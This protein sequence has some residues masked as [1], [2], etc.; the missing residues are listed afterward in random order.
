MSSVNNRQEDLRRRIHAAL[1]EVLQTLVEDLKSLEPAQRVKLVLQL[2]EY[3]LPRIKP[4]ENDAAY[5]A[6]VMSGGWMQ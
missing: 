2:S 5:H 4:D 6:E 1:D 3:V